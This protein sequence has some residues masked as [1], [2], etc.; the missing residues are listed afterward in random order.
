MNKKRLVAMSDMEKVVL[1]EGGTEGSELVVARVV[2][3]ISEFEHFAE[4]CACVARPC[5]TGPCEHEVPE[6]SNPRGKF[7]RSVDSCCDK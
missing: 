7:E 3:F 1:A 5:S 4:R 2:Y 6:C